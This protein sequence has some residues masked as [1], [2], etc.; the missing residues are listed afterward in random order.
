MICAIWTQW[1]ERQAAAWLNGG[2]G[3]YRSKEIYYRNIKDW[4]SAGGVE[5]FLQEDQFTYPSQIKCSI[6]F[7]WAQKRL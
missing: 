3:R 5:L 6:C 1:G 7:C 4:G 2:G